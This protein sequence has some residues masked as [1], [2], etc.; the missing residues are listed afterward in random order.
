MRQMKGVKISCIASSILPPGTTM[1]L[2][3]LIQESLIM[4]SR[5]WKSMPLGLAK[6]D[7]HHALVGA[8]N[9]ARDEGVG[10]VHHRH[11]LEVHVRV[12]ELRHDV[13]HVVGHAAQDGVGHRLGL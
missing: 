9:V 12:C 13:V 1:V 4:F 7:H 8:G 5:Y 11:A 6:A 3:R 10:G 2:A